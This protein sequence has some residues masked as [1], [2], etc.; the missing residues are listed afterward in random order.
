MLSLAQGSASNDR[1]GADGITKTVNVTVEREEVVPDRALGRW[2]VVHGGHDD[3]IRG[4]DSR[5]T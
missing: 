4:I 5:V 1:C 2:Q 3:I